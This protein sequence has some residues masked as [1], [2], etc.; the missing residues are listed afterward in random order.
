MTDTILT[1][2]IAVKNH[3]GAFDYIKSFKM[4]EKAEAGRRGGTRG[5]LMKMRTNIRIQKHL[6]D[7]NQ[8]KTPMIK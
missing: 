6:K 8:A 4:S 1:I 7:T 2:E 3:N 5:E